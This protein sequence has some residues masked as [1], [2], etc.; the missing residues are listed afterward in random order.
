MRLTIFV[1]ASL[2]ATSS[3]ASA[4]A[5]KTLQVGPPPQ[6]VLTTV[7]QQKLDAA[8]EA[9]APL[10][11]EIM[12]RRY[13]ADNTM[14]SAAGDAGTDRFE[15]YVSLSSSLCELAAS[16]SAPTATPGTGWHFSA[17]VLS[18]APGTMTA[19]FEWQRVWEN[20]ARVQSARSGSQTVTL[21]TGERVE[22]DRVTPAGPSPCG[23]VEAKLE[24][25]V[26]SRM[27]YRLTTLS[28]QLATAVG[29]GGRGAVAAGA[30]TGVATGGR[31]GRGAASG[32]GDQANAQA[33]GRLN[34]L[35]L[36][37]F[38]AELWLVHQRPDGSE[39]VQQQTARVTAANRDFTFP[40][41]QVQTSRGVITLDITGKLQATAEVGA[42]SGSSDEGAA[43]PPA[44]RVRTLYFFNGISQPGHRIMVAISRR[45]RA[46]GT[47]LL[48]ITGGSSILIDAPAPTD[49]LSFEFPP[50]QKATEDLLKGH[51][52]SLR[53]RI[54]PVGTGK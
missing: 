5:Q 23:A 34:F 35:Y 46:A 21:R 16:D 52:F 15:S 11:F 38:D 8:R 24:A 3:A 37:A 10:V 4:Q 20:G 25:G 22:L 44:G 14:A 33:R 26:S 48:D 50:L 9:S 29:R 40:P 7:A 30:A 31:G 2:L 18:S 39:S 51:L 49:V 13:S 42:A 32:T 54:T 12:V 28:G 19:R 36:P 41:I 47:P 1:V 6:K 17:E 43:A 53:V 27:A 45:A